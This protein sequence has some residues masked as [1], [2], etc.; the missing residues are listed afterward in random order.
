M[1]KPRIHI[2]T[3]VSSVEKLYSG[4]VPAHRTVALAPAQGTLAFSLPGCHVLSLT[5][6]FLMHLNKAHDIPCR[7][8]LSVINPCAVQSRC[9]TLVP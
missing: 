5:G 8:R 6:P 4:F 9:R 7:K 3:A 2:R 1:R